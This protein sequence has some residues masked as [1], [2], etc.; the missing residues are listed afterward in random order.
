MTMKLYRALLRFCPARLRDEY[1]AAMEDTFARRLADARAR[2]PLRFSQVWLREVGGLAAM[3]WSE[4]VGAARVNRRQRQLE[5]GWRAGPMEGMTLEVRQ[6]ARRL[7]RSPVFSIAAVL[8]LAMALAGNVAIFAVVERVVINPLPYHDADRLIKLTHTVPRVATQHFAAIPPGLFLE[9][10]DRARTLEAT[11]AYQQEDMTITGVGVPERVRGTL[12]TPSLANVL[13]IPPQ[14]GRWF[15]ADEG[16]PGAPRVAVLSHGFW[17]RRFGANP[18]VTGQAVMLNG[19]PT[20]IVGVMPVAH[21]FPDAQVDLWIAHQVSRASGFGLFTHT[22]VARV[23]SKVTL[24]QVAAELTG[25]I[26]SLPAAFPASALALSLS[27]DAGDT[28]RATPITLK[29][30]L[31]G[32]VTRA[33]WTLVAAVGLVL[34]IAGA[35]VANLV[36]VRS[37]SRQREVAVRRA[38]GGGRRGIVRFFLAES[39]LVS[40][41]GGVIGVLLAWA[42]VRLLVSTGPA[43]L[44][45]LN[46]VE[47]GW[48]T[49]AYATALTMVAAAAFGLIPLL[50]S[51]SVATALSEHGRGN[52]ATRQRHRTRQLLMAAQVAVALILLVAAGLMV[53]SFQNVRAIDPGFAPGSALTFRIALESANYADR[54]NAVAAHHGILD[55]LAALPGVISTSAA[56]C[57]PLGGSCW[58]NSIFVERQPGEQIPGYRPVVF[59]RAVAGGYFETMGTAVLRG[60]SLSRDD[61]ERREPHI[62]INQALADT[63]F[64]NL[65]P[66]GRRIASSR[67]PSYPAPAWLTI[68]GVVANAPTTGLVEPSRFMHAYLPMS[69]AGAP[70]IPAGELV[71]P[72]VTEMSYVVRTATSP[73]AFVSVIRDAV[74]DVDRSLAVAD[75]RTLDDL[76]GQASLQMAFTVALLAIAAAV[77]VML[78]VIGIYGVMAY[79][80][81]QRTAE[82]GVR[83]A[84]G[85]EPGSVARAIVRQGGLVALAGIAF[86]LAA[87]WA[88]SRFLESLLYNVSPRDPGIFAATAMVLLLVAMAACWLPARRAARL[89]PVDALR[90]E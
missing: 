47:L 69:L 39:V 42:A 11:A 2:G 25:L 58:G 89:S 53:R 67:P 41:A 29:E 62:V 74:D 90:M 72:D 17:V 87:A 45:R 86:G 68:V 79:I 18:A 59:F 85:A 1:A 55:R 23:R 70:A 65:D 61:I 63:Y 56:T 66:I 14:I 27:R 24:D 49:L 64:P 19:Q 9:Y 10:A 22:S 43:S 76:L 4:T 57:L 13:R 37:E 73:L 81:G 32:N 71:G 30:A 51:S 88:G 78:G 82:I 5:T 84:L 54:E 44:P 34:L 38:L 36:L 46:E 6:A 28:M 12:V 52:T 83:L 75:V 40:A 33:L 8:T 31:V 16:L 77:A 60:R 35:N 80:V 7:L 21:A 15:A 20:E 3:A 48:P 50:Y 26:R